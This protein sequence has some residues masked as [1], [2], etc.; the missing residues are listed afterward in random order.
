M[1]IDQLC[2][3]CNTGTF[4]NLRIPPVTDSSPPDRYGLQ[5]T[6]DQLSVDLRREMFLNN[7]AYGL[8][9]LKIQIL[10]HTGVD[11]RSLV[12]FFFS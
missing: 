2:H 8:K 6:E 4:S 5:V 9:C 10:V 1:P 3:Y 11:V 7:S 12:F